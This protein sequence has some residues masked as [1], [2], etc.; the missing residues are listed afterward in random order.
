MI[1]IHDKKDCCGCGACYSK[2]PVSAISMEEDEEGFLYPVTDKGRCIGCGLCEQVCPFLAPKSGN[3]VIESWGCKSLND[4]IRFESSSGGV[5]SLFSEYIISLGGSVFG[6]SMSEDCKRAV[7]MQV[8]KINQLKYLRGS[9][10]IQASTG[11]IF[12]TV[13]EELDRKRVVLFSG[14]PCQ[15]NGLK[16]YLGNDPAHLISVDIICHGVPSPLVWRKYME[17]AEEKVRTV[18]VSFRCKDHGWENYGIK[19]TDANHKNRFISKD[20]DAYIQFFLKDYCLRPSCYE[21]KV[22]NSRYSDVTIADFW[23]VEHFAPELNDGGGASFVIVRSP[24]GKSLLEKVIKNTESQ[25]V[26]Y[27]KV[28]RYNT[29]EYESKK[30]PDERDTFFRDINRL[31]FKEMERKYLPLSVNQRMK[32]V[33]KKTKKGLLEGK[34]LIDKTFFFEK[35]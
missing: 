33:I 20:E 23:G 8:H 13:K 27:D 24:K 31:S 21:C 25:K 14:T 29:A 19:R 32:R 30:R 11:E 34:K 26:D 18:A 16:S 22:K 9:K 4:K 10:Y 35:A 7:F 17:R 6:V 3:K 15:I 1:I 5:F 28:I 2:C 12:R